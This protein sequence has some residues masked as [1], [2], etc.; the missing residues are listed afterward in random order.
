MENVVLEV[1]KIEPEEA[2]KYQFYVV[3]TKK[4]IIMFLSTFGMYAF[5]WM[6]QNWNM[7][8]KSSGDNIWPIPRAIFDVFFIHSL[9][10]KITAGSSGKKVKTDSVLEWNATKYIAFVVI[11]RIAD[12]LSEED[13]GAPYI[14]YVSMLMFPFIC[15]SLYKIQIYINWSMDD[16]KGEGNTK[17][18]WANYS[19]I[20][21]IWGFLAVGIYGMIQV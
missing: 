10:S 8:K 3:S 6:Y 15:H 7:Y 5:Y 19:W 18:N 13:I 14:Y 21:V 4:F 12:R 17:L 9:C 20:A 2:V 16:E 11:A 1:E